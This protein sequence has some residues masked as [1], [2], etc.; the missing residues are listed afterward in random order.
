MFSCLIIYIL[1]WSRLNSIFS[2]GT[3]QLSFHVKWLLKPRILKTIQEIHWEH[4]NCKTCLHIKWIYFMSYVRS[5]VR[6]EERPRP[7]CGLPAPVWA[8]HSKP[9]SSLLTLILLSDPWIPPVPQV[10]SCLRVFT[11]NVTYD[12]DAPAPDLPLAF[13]SLLAQTASHA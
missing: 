10:N 12:W 4:V 8:Y 9:L 6:A 1:C 3:L 7:R 2:I 13:P 11:F 5:T